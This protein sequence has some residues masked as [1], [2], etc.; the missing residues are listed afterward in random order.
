LS[1]DLTL[2]RVRAA[3]PSRAT[4]GDYEALFRQIIGSP[5]D[6]RIAQRTASRRRVGFALAVALFLL[7]CGVATATYL[8]ARGN[9]RV[10][11]EGGYGQLLVVT[12]SGAGVRAVAPCAGGPSGCAVSEVAWSP[13]GRRV[14]L[15]RGT[16]GG[17][18]TRGR[19]ALYVAS[20]NGGP[21][22]LLATCGGCG[23]QW[24][25]RLAWSPEGT[26]IVFSRDDGATGQ[27][28]LWVVSVAG[29]APR[30]LTGCRSTWCADVDP[31]WSPNGLR[32]AFDRITIGHGTVNDIYTVRADGS[33]LARVAAG[34]DPQWSP[35]G[36]RIAYTGDAGLEVA[37]ADGAAARL[38]V[39]GRLSTGTGPGFPSWSPSG[40]KLVYVATPGRPGHFRFEVWTVNADGSEPKR[41]YRSGCCV[42]AYAPPLW[43]PD[44]RLIVFSATSA[45]GTFV[46]NADGS[47]LHR[48]SPSTSSALSW[49]RLPHR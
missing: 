31:A 17:R 44:G 45:R 15:V 28:A 5:G 37:E 40:A 6:P 10:A 27:E 47:G 8:L 22:R 36:T 13:D 25:G 14:A 32:L 3:N 33:Q 19:M 34:R 18:V 42:M 39:A 49:Q 2:E 7:L 1:R 46:M 29:G 48:L 26:R 11:L 30:R 12:P 41:V 24:G 38:V 21:G 4:A 20:A 35:D 9:G 16:G 43:S 23:Q